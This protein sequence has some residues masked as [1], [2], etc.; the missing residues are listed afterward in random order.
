MVQ[1]LKVRLTIK[2]RNV[3]QLLGLLDGTWGF[4][5]SSILSH[6]SG[7][8]PKKQILRWNEHKL[9]DNIISYTVEWPLVSGYVPFDN[10]WFLFT[11][12]WFFLYK[13]DHRTKTKLYSTNLNLLLEIMHLASLICKHFEDQ[14]IKAFWS[15][16]IWIIW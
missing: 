6:C 8:I 3:S 16:H 14:P 9:W 10:W 1:P 12:S 5:D 11:D 2:L 7:S 15:S 13:H 4:S